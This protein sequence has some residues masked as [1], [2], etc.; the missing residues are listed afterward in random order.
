MAP[1]RFSLI[2]VCEQEFGFVPHP[3]QRELLERLERQPN[4]IW[5]CGRRGGKSKCSA[6]VGLYDLLFRPDL[7]ALIE[8]GGERI[9][10]VVA[11]SRKQA[12]V[13]LNEA[14]RFVRHSPVAK[15][16]LVGETQEELILDHNA[17]RKVFRA[18][19]CS[20]RTLR[21]P[22]YSTGILDEAAYAFDGDA[23][24]DAAVAEVY[25]SVH[26]GTAEFGH[27]GRVLIVSS[28]RNDTNWFARRWQWANSGEDSSW[29]AAQVS[30]AEMNPRVDR[31]FL[32]TVRRTQPEIYPSEYEAEFISGGTSMF[33]RSRFALDPTVSTSEPDEA[34]RWVCGLD[35]A[36]SGDAFGVAFLGLTA[37]GT[38]VLGPTQAFEHDYGG[39]TWTAEG[40]RN[41]WVQVLQKVAAV[42]ERFNAEV[43]SDQHESQVVSE[44]L[45]R[46]GVE[47]TVIGM[48][49]KPRDEF[50]QPME[51]AGNVKYQ[52]F[53][54]LRDALYSGKLTLPAHHELF[55][56]I[57]GVQLKI[58]STGPRVILPRS[59]KGHRDLAQALALACYALT[60]R[61]A[62]GTAVPT[63]QLPMPYASYGTFG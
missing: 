46:F 21:G 45:S 1:R 18:A 47:A 37:D 41:A 36:I 17:R 29:W 54:E 43:F 22:A 3:K 44:M 9:S 48:N 2:A 12:T 49:G 63:V 28:P 16:C 58:D 52:S 10:V 40:K 13:V 38:F 42:C 23:D 24:S 61:Q 15:A 14:R 59:S 5:A 11:T 27:A 62:T 39:G 19:P 25:K 35:P 32:A 55:E 33:D 7:D 60:R 57:V 20:S 30:T 34:E 8:E 56:E 50:G 51:A 53:I 26:G 6:A 31:D 4:A